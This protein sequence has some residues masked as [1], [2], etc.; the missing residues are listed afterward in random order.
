MNKENETPDEALKELWKLMVQ[1]AN[2]LWNK[3]PYRVQSVLFILLW[4][5]TMGGWSYHF[6]SAV[7]NF[8]GYVVKTVALLFITAFADALGIFYIVM[9]LKGELRKRQT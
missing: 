5:F 7:L 4:I 3:I 9:E 1:S 6:V 2:D 8:D